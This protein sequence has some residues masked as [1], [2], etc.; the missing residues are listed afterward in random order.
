MEILRKQLKN[1]PVNG[2]EVLQLRPVVADG[3]VQTPGWLAP[4]NLLRALAP[5]LVLVI[6]NVLSVSG[7][8]SQRLF[9]SPLTV[10]EAFWDLVVTGQLKSA[11]AASLARG[12]TGLVIG[13]T[14]GIAAGTLAGLTRIGDQLLDSSFQIVRAIPFIAV[15]PLFV[16]WFGIDEEPKIILIALA[17]IFPAYVNTYSGVR[18]VDPKLVES[19]RLFGLRGIRLVTQIVLPSALPPILVG[20]RYSMSTALLALIVAEQ[21]NSQNGIGTIIL[22]ANSALR[23]DIMIAGI[24][25]YAALGVLIDVG[26]RIVERRSMPWK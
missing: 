20:I 18:H 21:L 16:L 2:K 22:T 10:L 13:V 1:S 23:I 19:A 9:P 7:I 6:W 8:I 25:I 26:M 5:V 15:V 14:L 17:C 12:V 4:R 24:L 3:G 11:L